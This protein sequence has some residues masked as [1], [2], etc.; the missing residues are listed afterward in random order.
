MATIVLLAELIQFA[1]SCK[2]RIS[3]IGSVFLRVTIQLSDQC[4]MVVLVLLVPLTK[5][6]N[7]L[8]VKQLV[9]I[10]VLCQRGNTQ[11][12]DPPAGITLVTLV[13]P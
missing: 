8:K 1:K 11:L 2:E 13:Q 9:I 3:M 7:K 6:A 5:Y 12:L 4:V 10:S